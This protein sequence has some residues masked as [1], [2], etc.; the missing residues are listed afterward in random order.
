M[1]GNGED[2]L[3]NGA[4]CFCCSTTIVSV[5][6][7]LEDEQNKS[8]TDGKVLSSNSLTKK[9]SIKEENKVSFASSKGNRDEQK[10][11]DVRLSK[12]D[13]EKI[14]S[15]T[16]EDLKCTYRGLDKTVCKELSIRWKYDEKTGKV[17]EMWCPYHIKENGE[18]VITGYKVR[19]AKP[20]E[21]QQKF[22]SIGYVGKLNCMFG[23]TYE[24]NESIV[25]V[26]G[27]IDVVSAIQMIR[28]G[29]SKY[30]SRKVTVVASPLGEPMTAELIK[31][32]WD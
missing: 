7:A 14:Y 22:Y 2:G 31:T 20:T 12:D 15:E 6:K 28:Q 30:P 26:G 10:L 11:K 13:L 21:K 32:N 1:Y 19:K 17:S 25:Y 27:E 16:S 24:V 29:L 8:T 23:E 18:L 4:F 3:S 5:E 9:S